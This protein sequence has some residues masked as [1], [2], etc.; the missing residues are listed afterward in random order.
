MALSEGPVVVS[1][2][3]LVTS[4]GSPEALVSGGKRVKRLQIIALSTNTGQVY[5]GGSDVA[6]TTNG[7][8]SASDSITLE[9]EGWMDLKDIHV[10][11]AVDGEGVDFYAVRA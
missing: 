6:A 9:A 1:G 5:I 4:A 10:D 11:A 2:Q 8:L 3:R 7:G